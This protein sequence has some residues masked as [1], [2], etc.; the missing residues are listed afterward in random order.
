[1]REGIVPAGRSAIDST[2]LDSE[3]ALA[4]YSLLSLSVCLSVCQSVSLSLS[5][6]QSLSLSLSVSQSVCS[7][8]VIDARF[9]RVFDS[10]HV[11]IA[12]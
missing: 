6:C 4:F 12:R 7:L 10:I 5:L 8:C 3:D 11:H 9:R 2:R 1:V